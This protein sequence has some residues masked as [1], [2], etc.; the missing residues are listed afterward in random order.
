M[1]APNAHNSQPWKFRILNDSEFLLFLD[2]SRLLTDTDP[3]ARQSLISQGTFLECLAIGASAFGYEAKIS[4][5]PEGNAEIGNFAKKPIA[6]IAL[7]AK[8]ISY[9]SLSEFLVSRRTTRT[10][11]TGTFAKQESESLLS[12]AGILRNQLGFLFEGNTKE[13]LIG[14]CKKAFEVETNTYRT[15]EETRKWFRYSDDE[16]DNKKDGLSFRG[17]GLTGF[18]H[19]LVSKFIV[20]P[21]QEV[22]HSSSAREGS[23]DVFQNAIAATPAFAWIQTKKD[24]SVSRVE[25]GRD[26][27]RICLAAEA[28]GFALHPVSQ[29]LE[30]YSEMKE[31]RLAGEKLLNIPPPAKVQMLFRLG[32][33]DYRYV[34]PRRNPNQLLEG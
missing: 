31:L 7:S 5:F 27:A 20:P 33:S 3:P 19:W 24:D 28:C 6:K 10:P 9:D 8:S 16:W 17:S 30:E 25:S 29:I 1:T 34:S 18:K 11:F 23:V 32:L 12:K 22:W 21:G 4:L 26:Y 14:F 15:N 2:P 13:E